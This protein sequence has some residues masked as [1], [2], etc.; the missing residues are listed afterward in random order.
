MT[1][2][3]RLTEALGFDTKRLWW[4]RD[5]ALGT[6]ASIAALWAVISLMIGN[7]DFDRHLGIACIVI[8]IVFCGIS[9]NRLMLFGV[10]VGFIALQGWFAVVFSHDV[11]SWWIAVPATILEVAF[12]VLFSKYPIRK[13][14]K[15]GN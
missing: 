13:Q 7:S 11:R 5:I 8:V 15:T 3:N 14:G 6:F 4:Y 10:V 2:I 9:P 1:T 12:F